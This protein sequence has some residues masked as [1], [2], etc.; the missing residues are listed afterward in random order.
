MEHAS[1][2]WL[3]NI[4]VSMALSIAILALVSLGLAVMFG[5]MGIINLAHGEF[6]MFGAYV[7]LTLTRLHTP[8]WLA[9][10]LAG[11]VV[12]VLGYAV[13]RL[14]IRFLYGRLADSMLATWGLSL[15][16]AQMTV[17]AFGPS[18]QGIST[19]LGSLSIDGYSFSLYA[20]VLIGCAVLLMALVYLMFTRTRYGVMA[21]AAV[22]N[23]GMAAAVGINPRKLNALNFAFG[24]ALAGWA[25]GLLAPMVGV[26]PSMG[27]AY[28]ARAF[29]T[30][31]VGG[32][33][34]ITGTASS[35]LLLGGIE[36]VVS[37]LSTP[38]FGQG[39]LLI[40]AIIAVRLLPT[41]ISG[42]WQRQL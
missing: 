21:R 41:G 10:P 13:E 6:L 30:V 22:Q 15:I 24:A 35:S 17:L 19:P 36:N 27:E 2:G 4:G 31:I 23:P 7:T 29:M 25:G 38:F 28:I 33:G 14:L 39:A 8:L 9:I 11:L 34:I 1:V 20:F 12:G 32:P 5:M 26:M 16:M 40:V 42:R 3:L 18:T 37:Y